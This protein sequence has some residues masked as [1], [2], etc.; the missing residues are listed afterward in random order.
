VSTT[1]WMAMM[2]PKPHQWV[3]KICWPIFRSDDNP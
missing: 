2:L 1:S 3:T